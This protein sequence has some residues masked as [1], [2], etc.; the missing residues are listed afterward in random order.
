M[1]RARG[2]G[3]PHAPRKEHHAAADHDARGLRERDDHGHGDG[4]LDERRAPLDRDGTLGRPRPHARRLP[5]RLRQDALPRRPQAVGPVRHGGPP[6]RRRHAGAHEVPPRRGVPRRRLPD[7]HGPHG[8]REPRR[9]R[10]LAR[11]VLFGVRVPRRHPAPRHPHQT[12]GAPP[13]HAR[14]PLPRRRGRQ[15][16]GQGGRVVHGHCESLRLGGSHARRPRREADPARL[17]RRHPVRGPQGRPRAPRDAHAD[18]GHHGRRPRRRHG[19]HHRRPLLG[20]LAR[21]LHRPR[22]ARGPARRPDRPRP[23]R[24]PDPHRRAQHRAHGRRRHLG[25]GDGPATRRVVAAAPRGD[26]RHALQV[27]LHRRDR[28]RGLRHRRS[29]TP[30]RRRRRQGSRDRRASGAA[31]GD[32]DLVVG[33]LASEFCGDRASRQGRRR[34]PELGWADRGAVL[35]DEVRGWLGGSP[36]RGGR[37]SACC[38]R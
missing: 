25:R 7:V 14:E 26:A 24:R 36:P 20:R 21:L 2:R 11:A 28:V 27:H 9:R 17:G 1:S 34:V 15:D 38:S 16:H 4:R 10:G 22:H 33:A 31:R 18:L 13:D 3:D 29:R 35:K 23:R 32:A 37:V 12:D 6:Q 8:P 30:R 5:A 19:A